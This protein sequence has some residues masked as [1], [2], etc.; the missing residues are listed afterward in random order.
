M[1]DLAE[2]LRASM[3]M[4]HEA[5][6]FDSAALLV[7]DPTT[8]LPIAGL[9][10]GISADACQGFWAAEFA[11]TGL[12]KFVDLARADVPVRTLI[13]AARS[14]ARQQGGRSCPDLP[15]DVT[16]IT[17][18]SEAGADESADRLARR[19]LDIFRPALFVDELRV[20]FRTGEHCR[21]FVHILRDRPF[22]PAELA[23]VHA[24]VRPVAG[25]LQQAVS[26]GAE[27]GVGSGI[28]IVDSA[29]RLVHATTDARG[30]L[31]DIRRS[32]PFEAE[33]DERVPGML[34]GLVARARAAASGE[35]VITR[36]RS[37]SGAWFRI[38]AART[39]GDDLVALSIEPARAS[40]LIPVAMASFGLTAREAHIAQ[41]LSRGLADKE[42][43]AE[44]GLS[45]HTVRDHVK[46]IITKCGVNSRAEVVAR[47]FVD[48]VQ[49]ALERQMIYGQ[50][51]AS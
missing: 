4:L 11:E 37:A 36:M 51:R 14:H 16:A 19:Y 7:V 27:A 30:L 1:P 44:L 50:D 5:V 8:L 3:A 31:A 42:I 23:R 13:E 35:A 15:P 21:A 9:V 32:S 26:R 47:I 20:A 29:G 48:Y 10:E 24:L 17:E 38:S 18:A 39:E 33:G 28:A 2:A 6:R 22:E 12:N 43:A 49:S 40:D 25:M 34:G 41:R 46:A 45:L